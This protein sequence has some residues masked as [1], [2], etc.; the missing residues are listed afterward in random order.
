MRIFIFS[1][2]VALL[3]PFTALAGPV[4][5]ASGEYPP[6]T[7][8]F[9]PHGGFV[10]H[11]LTEA[12][13]LVGYEVQITY[14]PWARAFERARSGGADAVSYCYVTEKRKREY[15]LSDQLTEERLVVFSRRETAVPDWKSLADFKGFRIGAT[16][17]FS[18]TDE[19]WVLVEQGVL[20]LDVAQH[21][22]Y[23]YKKLLN[24]RIDL[25][26]AD[27]LVGYTVLHER[28]APGVVS[29]IKVNDRAI[30]EHAGTLGFIKTQSGKQLRDAFN[31]G[32]KGLVDSGRFQAMHDAL[33]SGGYSR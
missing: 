5:V 19:F 23:N 16:R 9:L 29:M 1:I 8:E 17:G 32:L 28:F 13:R 26:F 21:D 30:A 18:Y 6:Y 20:T 15:W 14:Y 3:A 33:L 11:V 24:K 10:N 2:V 4:K 22:F 31:R 27:E 25:F 7:G 12:F